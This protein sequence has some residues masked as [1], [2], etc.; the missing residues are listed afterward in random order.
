[1]VLDYRK[2]YYRIK[3]TVS[4]TGILNAAHSLKRFRASYSVQKAIIKKSPMDDLP[5]ENNLSYYLL[6]TIWR[7]FLS[8]SLQKKQ[9]ICLQKLASNI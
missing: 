7:I 8:G 9:L 3:C 1:M 6:I 2:S 5:A 4:R